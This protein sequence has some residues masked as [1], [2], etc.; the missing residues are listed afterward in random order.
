MILSDNLRN[1]SFQRVHQ[2][3]NLLEIRSADYFYLKPSLAIFALFNHRDSRPTFFGYFERFVLNIEFVF[4]FGFPF[5]VTKIVS[6]F[7]FFDY[8]G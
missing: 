1:S 4:L 3:K 5:S 8:T 7:A 2:M 6:T